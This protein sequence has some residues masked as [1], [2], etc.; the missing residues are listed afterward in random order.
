MS[1]SGLDI[2]T[3]VSH[4]KQLADYRVNELRPNPKLHS[5]FFEITP[6]C[7]EHC[8]HCG[9]RCGDIDVSDMLSVSEYKSI[10]DQVS[11]DFDVNSLRLCITG[12][13]PLLRPEFFEI[14]AYAKAL[15]FHWGMTTNGTLITKEVAKKLKETGMKT[16]S[17][18]VDGLKENHEWFR[19]SEGS[20]QKTMDGIKNLV[21]EGFMHVQI[22]TVIY[23]KNIHEL[24]AM[25]EEFRKTGV[26]SWR[27]INIEPIG[28]AKDNP[29]LM[30]T[31]EEYKRLFNFIEEKRFENEM[32]VSYG[33][34]HYLGEELER[35]V[36]KWYFL[37]NAG[38]Y[39]ASITYDGNI[40]A[41]LD[42]ERRPE[43]IEG[44]IRKDKL[45]DVWLNGFKIYRSDYRKAG[46]CAECKDYEF[47]AGDSYHTWNFDTMEPNICMRE[48]LHD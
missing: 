25:Y 2:N 9:S 24:E 1:N 37:C 29:E 22:T 36:R 17:V 19:Q 40:Q 46:K 5:L 43:L 34:S 42:I 3:K 27:V 18:S 30:L 23:H 6:Y 31:K 32:E 4:M 28:R 39:V 8:L 7:N 10:L 15:G 14:M 11:Q 48:I 41:C 13:E 47:C 38:V 21:D 16:I 35:E 33:C 44:N 26:R 45:K 20:Y 12:G